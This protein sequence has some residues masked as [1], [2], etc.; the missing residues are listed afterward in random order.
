MTNP[1]IEI[2]RYYFSANH[3]VNCITLL[4]ADGRVKL[5]VAFEDGIVETLDLGTSPE[6][7]V[8]R[9]WTE[10]SEI[11]RIEWRDEYGFSPTL[12]V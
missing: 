10:V 3:K 5:E 11:Q 2:V 12:A 9:A 1:I 7:E 6:H 4:K 8:Y